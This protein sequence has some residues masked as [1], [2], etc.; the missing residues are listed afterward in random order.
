M[1]VVTALAP[2]LAPFDPAFQDLGARNQG[3]SAAHLLGT[4]DI[5]RDL[6]SRLLYGSR[7]T[8]LAA[9]EATVVAV[10]L[11][12]PLGL[13]AGYVGKVVDVT[14]NAV[15]DAI[16]SIPPILLAVVIVG[17]RGP[18]LTNAMV[19]VGIIL[20]PRFYRIAR[21][22]ASSVRHE[23]YVESSRAVGCSTTRILLRHVLPNTSGPLLVQVSFTVGVAVVAE[24][25]LSFLGLGVQDPEASLGSM[26][27]SAGD[28]VTTSVWPLLPPSVVITAIILAFSVLGDG[29]RD[30]LGRDRE[31]A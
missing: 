27:Q 21:A 31:G 14:A 17:V 28:T 3:P 24:A 25:S 5:G 29:I 19:A 10:V 26:V 15:A 6:L 2:V 11:G 9:V 16:M 1:V 18:G 4:D 20:A 22:A 30:A 23:A 12:L 7:L 13:I 8:L